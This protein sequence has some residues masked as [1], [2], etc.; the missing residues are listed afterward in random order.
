M[1]WERGRILPTFHFLY[2]TEGAGEYESQPT[3]ARRLAAGDLVILQ[4]GMWHR[5][6]P[7]FDVGWHEY[8]LEFDGDHARRLMK[9]EEFLEAGPVIR[10]GPCQPFHEVIA[11]VIGLLHK[12]RPGTDLILGA[13]AVEAIAEALSALKRREQGGRPV[14]AIIREAKTLLAQR[15]ASPRHMQEFAERLSMSY[16]AF[17]RLFRAETGY[18]PRQFVLEVQMRRAEELL[19]TSDATISRVAEELGFESVYY[20]SRLF[21]KK[22]GNT[23]SAFRNSARASQRNFLLPPAKPSAVPD[24]CADLSHGDH[25]R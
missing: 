24:G 17:R 14:S 21:K 15:H 11:R 3:G 23:P 9:R 25:A 4:P 13:L 8:W 7:V 19:A 2:I 1:V 12:E 10:L 16:S 5:Y 22:H 6:R 18:S 20:F